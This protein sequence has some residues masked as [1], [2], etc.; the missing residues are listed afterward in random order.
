MQWFHKA[1][2][3]C[4]WMVRKATGLI[5]IVMIVSY[6][7][8]I[9][10]G[11]YPDPHVHRWTRWNSLTTTP[12]SSH[13]VQKN[14]HWRR[15]VGFGSF[16]F[17]AWFPLLIRVE[18]ATRVA[19]FSHRVGRMT[20][21]CDQGAQYSVLHDGGLETSKTEYRQYQSVCNLADSISL[22]ELKRAKCVYGIHAWSHMCLE[23]HACTSSA[24]PNLRSF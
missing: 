16:P 5:M 9:F 11:D 20:K 4:I 23:K 14:Q 24:A 13:L 2:P 8:F 22:D 7:P 21:D 15:R 3:E 12:W 1:N 6:K 19:I 18:Y 10:T 17:P